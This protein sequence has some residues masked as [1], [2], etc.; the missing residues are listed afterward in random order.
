LVE[1]WF[2]TQNNWIIFIFIQ[3]H[4][5][6]FIFI[7]NKL[8]F[9]TMHILGTVIDHVKIINNIF[10]QQLQNYNYSRQHIFFTD[11]EEFL[12]YKNMQLA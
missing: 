3:R 12:Q 11:T 4:I 1:G 6:Y 5:L 8:K 9:K 7:K 2:A 10:I